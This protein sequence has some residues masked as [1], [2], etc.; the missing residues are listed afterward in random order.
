MAKHAKPNRIPKIWK[1]AHPISSSISTIDNLKR[2]LVVN[3]GKQ[4]REWCVR[5]VPSTGQYIVYTDRADT[6][7]QFA[8]QYTQS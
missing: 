1:Y 4:N 8:F 7:I 3:V 5:Y 2:W 6:L